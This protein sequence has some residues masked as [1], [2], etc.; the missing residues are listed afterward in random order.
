MMTEVNQTLFQ[1]TATGYNMQW[2]NAQQN[3]CIPVAVVSRGE[4]AWKLPYVSFGDDTDMIPRFV[5]AAGEH[6]A[7]QGQDYCLIVGPDGE[8]VRSIGSD[9][10]WPVVLGD[11]AIAYA[12][13]FDQLAYIRYDG[14]FLVDGHHIPQVRDRTSV[15]LLKPTAGGAYAAVQYL[16]GIEGADDPATF[17]VY[18]FQLGTAFWDWL[19]QDKGHLAAAVLSADEDKIVVVRD[20]HVEVYLTEDGS[21]VATFET[22]FSKAF[23]ASI[24]P[25]NTLVLVGATQEAG[26][27]NRILRV[28]DLNGTEIWS[29]RLQTTRLDQPPV[30]GFDGK[31]YVVNAGV[32]QAISDGALVWQSTTI[33]GT[34]KWLTVTSDSSVLA[35]HAEGLSLFDSSGERRFDV[36][37]EKLED[38]FVTPAVLDAEGRILVAGKKALYCFK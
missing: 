21:Q 23:K 12:N 38:Q 26:I 16:G 24:S 22:G 32:V 1:S 31:V 2:A 20:D 11:S 13:P 6:I 29:F 27:E 4:L 34:A 35:V 33:G 15:L 14:S 19:V 9:G 30:C 28:F 18:R 7:V 5:L 8:A 37:T 36:T 3:S 25:E 17:Y 10:L